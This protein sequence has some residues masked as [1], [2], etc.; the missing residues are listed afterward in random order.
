MRSNFVPLILVTA[1]LAM[2]SAAFASTSTTGSI[3]AIDAKALSV[4]LSDG[5]VYQLPAGFVL[6]PFKVGEKV[7][8][9][10]DLKGVMHEAAS[11]TPA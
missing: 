5:T 9:M 4:T 7:V 1:A 6:T 10:W 2:G 11:M 3:K 8:I